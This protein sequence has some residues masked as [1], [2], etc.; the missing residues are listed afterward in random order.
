MDS[1]TRN[2]CEQFGQEYSRTA[3]Q[4]YFWMAWPEIFVYSFARNIWALF[5]KEY[6]CIVLPGIFT[7]L[8]D[9]LG[10]DEERLLARL[11]R[12]RLYR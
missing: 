5:G 12:H 11:G 7:E 3:G 4:E 8:L 1:L 6:L 9:R 10:H 2:I